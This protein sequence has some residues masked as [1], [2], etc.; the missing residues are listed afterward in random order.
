MKSSTKITSIWYFLYEKDVPVIRE[1]IQEWLLKNGVVQMI[2]GSDKYEIIKSIKEE[3][4]PKLKELKFSEQSKDLSDSSFR[5]DHGITFFGVTN[6][7][8]SKGEAIKKFGRIFNVKKKDRISIGDDF[9][10]FSMFN[11]CDINVAMGNALPELKK[12][13]SFITDTNENDG[14]AKFLET[15]N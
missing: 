2:V 6:Q 14:V 1:P 7:S 5:R 11:E 9:N 13:A 4:L 10:D 12:R 15:I 3:C 8:T